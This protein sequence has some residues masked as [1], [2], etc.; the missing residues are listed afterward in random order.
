M[1]VVPSAAPL[2]S[3]IGHASSSQT[4][5][6]T[7]TPS[8]VNEE[9]QQQQQPPQQQQMLGLNV[10]ALLLGNTNKPNSTS[11][12][13]LSVNNLATPENNTGLQKTPSADALLAAIKPI[14]QTQT[15]TNFEPPASAD[16]QQQQQQKAI[17]YDDINIFLWSVC[18]I[19]NKV[20]KCC[21]KM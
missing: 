20:K 11:A 18:K 19:C 14:I 10:N 12:D 8:V 4:A 21:W 6:S 9:K 15:T 17:V 16:Q 13:L 3:S 7:P 2:V 5:T 1:S